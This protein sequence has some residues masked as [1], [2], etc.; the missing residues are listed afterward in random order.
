VAQQAP[1]R[2]FT[3]IRAVVV[4]LLV[5]AAALATAQP[6][7]SDEIIPIDHPA[8]AYNAT[9][10]KNPVAALSDRLRSAAMDLKPHASASGLLRPLLDALDVPVESQIAVFAAASLQANRIRPSNPRVIYFNDSVAVAWVRGGFVEIAAH[11]DEKGA[12]FYRLLQP[13][14]GQPL[15]QRDMA[16][17]QCHYSA[18]TLGVPGF[19]A[20]SI[21]SDTRGDILPWLGNYLID[22]RSPLTERWGGWYVTGQTSVSSHLGNTPI[23]DRSLQALVAPNPGPPLG[24]L[25]TRFDTSNYLTPHSDVVALLVFEHQV[26]LMNLLSRI[27]A[28]ARIQAHDASAGRN[29]QR[30]TDANAGVGAPRRLAAAARE[31]VDYMLFVDEAPLRGVKGSNGFAAAFSARGPRDSKGRSLRDLDLQ[32]RLMRYPCSYMIYSPAFDGLPAAAKDAVYARMWAVLS[33]GDSAAKYS[34]LTA[35]D[36]A[37]VIEILRETKRDLPA[38]FRAD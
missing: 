9:A 35:T 32:Q 11:D 2:V 24:D 38:Y 34:R 8:I 37:A 20:R 14:V 19:M 7:L 17:L 1:T 16:C 31:I 33:G 30:P 26:H 3:P 15:I 18:T 29:A 12:V 21:P 25:S 36:R 27:G 28:E 23:A 10:T 5:Y 4:L 22:H 13:P 6:Q